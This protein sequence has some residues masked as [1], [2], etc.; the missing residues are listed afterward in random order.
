MSDNTQVRV[1]NR[2][3]TVFLSLSVVSFFVIPLAIYVLLDA[4]D[5]PMKTFNLFLASFAFIAQV[6]GFYIFS[7]KNK[8]YIVV[9]DRTI[10]VEYSVYRPPVELNI[11]DIQSIKCDKKQIRIKVEGVK[12]EVGIA[13]NF[14]HPDERDALRQFFA[15]DIDNIRLASIFDV[16]A[17]T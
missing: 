6:I 7:T 15:K 5:S 3:K 14:I 2:Y 12:K 13:I 11:R 17:S 10:S 16:K 8:P 4:R 1:F 9:T